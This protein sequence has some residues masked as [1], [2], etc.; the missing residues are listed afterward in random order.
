M[1]DFDW[2]RIPVAICFSN[3]SYL[4]RGMQYS[5][6]NFQKNYVKPILTNSATVWKFQDFAVSQIL[7]E[8]NFED[9]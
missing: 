1:L 7:R 2:L 6:T 3:L 8:I 5:V 4:V 9:S